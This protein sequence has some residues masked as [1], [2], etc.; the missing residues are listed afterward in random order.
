[1]NTCRS[2]SSRNASCSHSRAPARLVGA[3]SRR[4]AVSVRALLKAKGPFADQISW[5]QTTD[6]VLVEV[7][8]AAGVRGRDVSFEIHP[9]RLRLA[10]EGQAVLEG[11]LADAGEVTVDECFWT[12]ETRPDGSRY[13]ALT[14]AKRTSGYMSWEALLESDKPDCSFTHRVGLKISIAGQP[15][16]TVVCGLYGNVVPKTVEN[17]RALVTGEKGTSPRSGR[18]LHLKGCGFHRIIPG[19]MLQG[20]DFTHG[21]GTGGE[22]IYGERFPDENF[23]LRHD[24]AGLLAMANAGPDTNGSQFYI[25]LAPQPHLDGKHV[26]FGKV[27][28]G[29]EVIRTMENEG[30]SSGQ[31]E[32]PVVIEDCVELP[33]GPQELDRLAE[34]NKMLRLNQATA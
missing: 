15:A 9:R 29:M 21:D 33:L 5:S 30:S 2:I 31:V 3:R 22:S 13:V 32:R 18:P 28:V 10:V 20:G 8:V 24:T 23:K 27:E 7:P 1:M 11:G 16:G 26:V 12:L 34:E 4:P 19:F 17:F 6:E 14:L 25:T